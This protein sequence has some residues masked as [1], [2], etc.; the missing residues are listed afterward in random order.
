MRATEFIF[1]GNGGSNAGGKKGKL[2]PD[3]QSTMPKA[4]KFAGTQDRIYDLHRAM[5]AVA[6]SDGKNFT[7][8]PTEES[9]IGRSNMAAPYTEQEHNMLHHAYDAIGIKIDDAV[10]SH[11]SEPDDI[12]KVSPH[13]PFKGYKR[14]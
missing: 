4:H 7:H 1:E 12:N 14:K 9:W 5:M 6:S 13:K 8:E 11:G 3:Q 10:D 2:H